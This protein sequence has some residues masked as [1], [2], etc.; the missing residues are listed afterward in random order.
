MKTLMAFDVGATNTKWAVCT[1]EYTVLKQGSF[2]TPHTGSDELAGMLAATVKA[3]GGSCEGICISILGTVNNGVIE[4]GGNL[5][6]MTGFDL[7]SSLSRSTGLCVSVENDGKCNTLGELAAGSLK[8]CRDRVSIVLG[9]GVG[10]GIIIDGRLYR[11]YGNNAGEIGYS[12]LHIDRAP[13]LEYVAGM[14]SSYMGLMDRVREVSDRDYS[15]TYEV[16]K[17]ANNGDMKTLEG[18]R[19]YSRELAGLIWN[20]H[21]TLDPERISIGGGITAEELLCDMITEETF[22]LCDSFPLPVK[23]PVIVF[24]KLGNTANLFGAVRSY[25]DSKN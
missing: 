25:L 8:G 13:Q 12:Y 10:A 20:L 3:E 18:I 15:N 14:R 6:F 22:Q 7:A 19:N 24:S 4:N 17:E 21:F 23:K 9:T 5:P 16:F 2:R 1:D 11:G